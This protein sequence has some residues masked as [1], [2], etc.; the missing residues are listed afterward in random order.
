MDIQFP[1]TL[2]ESVL[3]ADAD[4]NTN[5]TYT[6]SSQDPPRQANTLIQLPK[7]EEIKPLP[8]RTIDAL[9]NRDLVGEF[10]T[11]LSFSNPNIASNS[12]RQFEIGQVLEFASETLPVLN[13]TFVPD[14]TEFSQSTNILSDDLPI[15][16]E[17]RAN[18]HDLA[19]Q[20]FND[21]TDRLNSLKQSIANNKISISDAQKSIN[22]TRKAIGSL[23]V[24]LSDT[25]NEIINRLET[26][27]SG[28]I[29]ERDE[30]V[31]ETNALSVEAETAYDEL[32]KVREFVR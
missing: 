22:E 21:L 30:L 20:Q 1:T 19:A 29:E 31:A 2:Y 4:D 14:E 8:Q 3:P 24:V 7:A 18:I 11:A 5:I 32:L 6:I 28:L 13:N 10:L 15:T 16:E 9:T 17:E 25:D 26:S 12:K 27:L 23:G